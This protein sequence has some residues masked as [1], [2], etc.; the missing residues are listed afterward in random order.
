MTEEKAAAVRAGGHAKKAR[1][2]KILLPPVPI[3]S[4]QDIL[5]ILGENINAVRY[6][7]PTLKEAG[8]VGYLCSHWLKAYEMTGLKNQVDYINEIHKRIFDQ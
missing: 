2:E 3:H 6:K 1:K 5:K 8:V 4:P 7:E